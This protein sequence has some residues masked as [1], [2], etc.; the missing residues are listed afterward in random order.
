MYFK[1]IFLFA[2]IWWSRVHTKRPAKTQV[3]IVGGN[4]A[5]TR[6]FPYIVSIN[7]PYIHMHSCGASIISRRWILTAAHCLIDEDVT[8][9]YIYV[10][11]TDLAIVYNT[12]IDR[13]TYVQPNL[14][15]QHPEYVKSTRQHD[16]G[17]L[18]LEK[19]LQYSNKV[20]PVKLHAGEENLEKR[21]ATTS[22]WGRVSVRLPL[23]LIMLFLI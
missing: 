10:G 7:V 1:Q 8:N 16:I 6:L 21:E 5:D 18:R 3:R 23:P 15:I 20:Q 11:T 17:L 13:P 19:L 2:M 4:Y 9:Y 12:T 14:I 22:G